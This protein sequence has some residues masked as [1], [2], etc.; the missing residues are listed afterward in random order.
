MLY[1]IQ[2]L[3]LNIESK[4]WIQMLN[5][6][7]PSPPSSWSPIACSRRISC[8]GAFTVSRFN[9][10]ESF[11]SLF[12]LLTYLPLLTFTHLFPHF[13]IHSSF[14]RHVSLS[15][16]IWIFL[17]RSRRQSNVWKVLE[18]SGRFLEP[19]DFP[20]QISSFLF[21]TTNLPRA[22]ERITIINNA[23]HLWNE[24]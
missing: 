3:N 9:F 20:F 14:L 13:V 1:W 11:I 17:L 5:P 7:R 15:W 6:E 12:R 2:M 23:R 4:C 21:S 8:F 24:S 19:R 10:C 22:D 16:T 18:G